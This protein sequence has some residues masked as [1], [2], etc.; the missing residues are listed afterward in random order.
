MLYVTPVWPHKA[1]CGGELRSLNVLRA[2][3]QMGRVEVVVLEDEHKNGG[4]V[5]EL[6][7]DFKIA[8]AL[9]VKR[10][11]NKDLIEKLRWTLD[12]RS[13]YPHGRCV[14]AGAM[15]RI[16]HSVHEFDLIWFNTL[17]SPDM[18]PNASWPRSVVDIDDVPSLY[19]R[20]ILQMGCGPRERLLALR[21]VFSWSRREKLLGDRFTVLA[22]CS[23]ADRQY[24]TRMGV[25]APIHVIPNG[26]DRPC[27]E[28]VRRPAAPPRI[29][30]IGNFDHFP[31]REGIHWFTNRC[32]PQIK[33]EVPD[34]RLRLVG[35][36]S[37][38]PLKPPGPDIDGLGWLANAEDEIKTWSVMVVPIRIGAGTRVK[39]AQG[40]SQK[41]PIV[42]TSLGA[43]GYGAVDGQEMYLADTSATFSNG[44]INAIR[45]PG[46]AAQMAERAWRQFLKEW[47]WDA[48]RPLVWATAEDCLRRNGRDRT[49][50]HGTPRVQQPT[51]QFCLNNSSEEV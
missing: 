31:N 24:L 2:L 40:F 37:D 1:A 35:S 5:S 26:F 14:A 13:H 19:E 47:T 42:S 15:G 29:G 27:V 43:Y 28:P 12:P 11:P 21:R 6:G 4:P 46:R 38:G 48:I 34:A 23:D 49:P 16:L 32:W 7:N 3:Q 18:F 33:C 20:A 44:C 30:F 51:A 8:Y 39:I 22:A 25:K 9:A 36:G 17:R 10:R 45:E 41:C 50:I